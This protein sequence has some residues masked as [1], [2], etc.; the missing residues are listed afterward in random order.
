MIKFM[1][2]MMLVFSI[3]NVSAQTENTSLLK[4]YKKITFF[5]GGDSITAYVPPH[6][7]YEKSDGMDLVAPWELQEDIF[8]IP[9]EVAPEITQK[10]K[11]KYFEKYKVK[12][13]DGYIS[14]GHIYH[15]FNVKSAISIGD[16]WLFVKL[17]TTGKFNLYQLYRSPQ[18]V[19]T[20]NDGLS[21]MF[22]NIAENPI[23]VFHKPGEKKIGRY[24][25]DL[26]AKRDLSDCQVVYDKF[27]NSE[28]DIEESTVKLLGVKLTK[29]EEVNLLVIKDYN[30]VCQ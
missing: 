19:S 23:W 8:A 30:S 13:Y 6:F 16:N 1:G 3:I 29:K 9:E 14:H 25:E 7:G 11:S 5:T 10:V 17:V 12:D 26:M 22:V 24:V 21:E 2:S 27:K 20:T 15:S 28:Y 4:D 18:I